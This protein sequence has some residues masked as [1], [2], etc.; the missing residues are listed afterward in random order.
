[1]QK[2]ARKFRSEKG[3][4]IYIQHHPDFFYKVSKNN[5]ILICVFKNGCSTAA[6]VIDMQ[7]QAVFTA[8]GVINGDKGF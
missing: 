1:M 4:K 7:N 8:E 2:F 5:V 6:A 3:H